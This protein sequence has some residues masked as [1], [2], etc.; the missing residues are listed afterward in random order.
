MHAGWTAPFDAMEK[1]EGFDIFCPFSRKKMILMDGLM[2]GERNK[3]DDEMDVCA[4]EPDGPSGEPLQHLLGDTD[5]PYEPDLED[6]AAEELTHLKA[7][8]HKYEAFLNIDGEVG[9]SRSQHK[10]SILCIFSDNNANSTDRLKWV[11]D[12]SRFNESGSGLGFGDLSDPQEPKL[13]IQDPAATLV[14]SK[15]LIWL[16]VVQIVDIRLDHLGLQSLPT[17][18]LG[19]PNI[20]LRVQLMCLAPVKLGEE[21]ENG[22]WEWTG[23]F[24]SL[25]G[26]NSTFEVDSNWIQ[27]LN[28]ATSP[29]TRQGNVNLMTYRFL[30]AEIVAVAHLLHEKIRSQ[31]DRLPTVAWSETFPYRTRNGT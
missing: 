6:M 23:R 7:S 21:N 31:F 3:D 15:N 17:R 28:P 26:T 29:P 4:P 8:K 25:T 12:L 10:A 22:D 9:S 20:Q 13:N 11:Q 19:Q 1:G 24:E 5:V 16:A 27:L 18:L 2:E 14:R 30:S